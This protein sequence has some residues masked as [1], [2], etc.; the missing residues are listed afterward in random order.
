MNYH[1]KFSNTFYKQLPS[2][3]FNFQTLNIQSYII[4]PPDPLIQRQSIPLNPPKFGRNNIY[5]TLSPFNYQTSK[6]EEFTLKK[7]DHFTCTDRDYSLDIYINSYKVLKKLIF[8]K[9]KVEKEGR[10]TIE[11]IVNLRENKNKTK[12]K[13]NKKSILNYKNLDTLELIKNNNLDLNNILIFE[14]RFES[15]N[16]QL[17]Y[18]IE[19]PYYD[20]EYFNEIEKY[21]L[22]LHN[23]TNTTGYTQWFFF[24]VSNTKKNKKVNFAIMNLM[25]KRTRYSNGLKIWFYSKKLNQEKNLGWHHTIEE[26]KYYKNSLYRMLKGKRQYYYTLSFDFTFPYDDDEIYFANCIP[27]T[28]TDLMRKLNEYQKYENSKY[29]YFHRKTLCQTL[30]G[31]D[32]DYITINNSFITINNSNLNNNKSINFNNNNIIN[33]SI[34][35]NNYEELKKISNQKEGVVLIGR[36]HPSETV[37]SWALNGAIDFLLSES[38]EAKY[39]RDNI[40]F[41]IIPMINV[42]GVIAG[43]TRTSFAGCDLNRRWN[44]P[45][46]FLHPEIYYTKNLIMKFNNQR[47]I[48][49][50]I[51]FHGHFG[52]FNSFFYANH[53][54][55]FIS[56]KFFPFSTSKK[57]S[58]ISFEKSGFSMPK[59]KEGTGRINLFKE[60]N[61]ENVVTLE[62]S[63]FG[64]V[65]GNYAYQYFNV[66]SL[67]EIGRDICIGI[68]YSY[69]HSNNKF[70]I[71]N[72]INY[73]EM[74][75]KIE[76]ENKKIENEFNKYIEDIK[77]KK[78]N[79]L[80]NNENIK[81]SNDDLEEDYD[82]ENAQSESESEPSLDNLDIEE[83]KKLLPKEKGNKKK[84]KS[85]KLKISGLSS[86]KRTTLE[87]F[88]KNNINNHN[89]NSVSLPKLSQNIISS[90][91]NST[92]N[93]NL[94]S[95]NS[96]SKIKSNYKINSSPS[97]NTIISSRPERKNNVINNI[98]ITSSIQISNNESNVNNLINDE[99]KAEM[100]TQTEEIFFKMHWSYFI[101]HFPI[102]SPENFERYEKN[103]PIFVGK[104]LTRKINSNRDNNNNLQ[105]SNTNN[106]KYN[107]QGSNY[108]NYIYGERNNT[109]FSGNYNINITFNSLAKGTILLNKLPPK[110][111]S[112]NTIYSFNKINNATINKNNTNNSNNN[113]TQGIK[114][115]LRTI[116]TKHKSNYSL[117]N[118]EQRNFI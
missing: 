75:N 85:K 66:D 109:G 24:R 38:D 43:N 73:P 94:K 26:V 33:Y 2:K 81:N 53:K 22:F 51:D 96:N 111:S 41:K 28:Y 9:E 106:N 25:R 114:L 35:N 64:C 19:S 12:K 17:A 21:Q 87:L 60:F 50:I 52:A 20:D 68:L 97:F 72:L 79:N 113:L 30:S 99:N 88:N 16:L 112:N 62:T 95:P 11:N 102:L 83:I 15:G 74:K 10:V 77:N 69:Y 84:K 31:N 40:I 44:N 57:S 1:T 3:N 104:K 100:G 107:V 71:E 92:T 118:I 42:D 37:G 108:N 55:D 48:N 90:S 4:P 61:I 80:N 116:T 54:D 103:N 89:L 46:E 105:Y 65:K 29:P 47:K 39:L 36:Q 110:K 98:K 91:K 49:Y 8:S 115:S 7:R 23:D 56:C 27:Y 59:F 6:T 82:I 67:K 14:S 76:D 58:I 117:Q 63:Y 70:G 32:V 86:M 34:N 93:I 13:N 5:I 18:L 78:N 101:G 45:N